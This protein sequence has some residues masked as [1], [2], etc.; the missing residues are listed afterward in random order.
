M[1][2]QTITVLITQIPLLQVIIVEAVELSNKTYLSAYRLV[3]MGT[4]HRCLEQ[5]EWH[6]ILLY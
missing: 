6:L 4:S 5:I 2:S 1:K 3:Q